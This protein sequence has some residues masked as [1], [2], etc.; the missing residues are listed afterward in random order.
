MSHEQF[1]QYVEWNKC[2]RHQ[3]IVA[4]MTLIRGMAEREARIEELEE[5]PTT[6]AYEQVCKA[7]HHWRAEAERLAKICGETPRQMAM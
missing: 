2:S 7:L 4:H 1:E 6:F 3:L 5:R